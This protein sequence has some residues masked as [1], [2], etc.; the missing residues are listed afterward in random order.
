[1]HKLWNSLL[2]GNRTYVGGD[3]AGLRVSTFAQQ[4]PPVTIL[5]C[6]DSRVP[7]ELIFDK[8]INDLFVV[9]VAGNI[10]GPYEIA[11]I[12][13]GIVKGYTRIVL[14][15][16]HE[17]CGVIHAALSKERM[18]SANMRALVKKIRSSLGGIR[19]KRDTA[20]VRKAVEANARASAA[21]LLEHSK[22]IRD[23]AKR[24]KITLVTAYYDLDEGTVV[25]L[26]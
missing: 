16:G 20:T 13:Y 15:M 5:S 10:A 19:R 1:M 24:G 25:R 7:A 11:S 3:L 8:S 4:D 17:E 22:I 2:E 9:R 12:E 6:S 21:D 18:P 14:V 26:G 23:A